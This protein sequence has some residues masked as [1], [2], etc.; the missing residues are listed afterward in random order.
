[1]KKYIVLLSIISFFS[2]CTT[3][4]SQIIKINEWNDGTPRFTHIDSMEN[5]EVDSF[6][7][8][9]TLT[10]TVNQ[11]SGFKFILSGSDWEWPAN[12]SLIS[13]ED[14]DYWNFLG[15]DLY[16]VTDGAGRRV[17]EINPATPEEVWEFKGELGTERYLANPVDAH[18][19][20]E[21]EGQQD[22]DKILITD[23]GRHRVIKVIK[24]NK[25]IQ[26]QYGT[27][28]EGSG[29]NE[30]SDPVDAVPI[31]DS[32]KVFIC[33]KGNKRI[34]LVNEADTSIVWK[35]EA[36]NI[37]TPVDIEYD[38]QN[39]EVLIT[40]QS[41]HTVIKVNVKSNAVTWRFG[42]R[43]VPGAENRLT[44]P[45]DAD[46]LPNG[47]ILICDAG[48]NRLIE[49][50]STK[51]IVWE[52]AKNLENLK[53]ADRL[54]NNKHLIVAGNLP[55]RV[56][57]ISD[58]FTS[59]IQDL[60]LRAS[61]DSLFWD[62]DTVNS[63]TSLK[64][65]L[66][67]EN[68][69]GDIESAEWYG[70][71]ATDSFYTHSGTPINSIHN[72]HR[73]CQ[74]K[75]TLITNNPLYTPQLNDL[76]V[77]YNYYDTRKTG[78]IVTKTIADSIDYIITR[79]KT[80]QYNTIL[81]ENTAL[82]ND[83]EIKLA[84]FD[85]ETNESIASFS[86]S[87]VDTTNEEAL[88]NIE[89]LKK[90]Q[91]IKL[92]ATLQ[93]NNASV[94]PI[95]NN[96]RLEWEKTFSSESHVKFVDENLDSAAYYRLSDSYEPGQPYIDR[97]KVLLDDLNLEQVQDAM[98]LTIKARD[99]KDSILVNLHFQTASGGYVLQP[100]LPAIVFDS[101]VPVFP[102]IL[103]VFDRDL[104][105]V[106]Y[107][108]PTNS[109]D[110]SSDSILVIKDT[111]GTIE[112]ENSA[113]AFIDSVSIGDSVFVHVFD[114][115]DRNFSTTDQD[116]I[117]ITLENSHSRDTEE[118]ILY[119]VAD[120]LGEFNTGEFKSSHGLPLVLD[121]TSSNFDGLL[122][123]IPGSI[124]NIDKNDSY[125]KIPTLFIRSDAPVP[126]TSNYYGGKPLEFQIAPN[127]YYSDAHQTLRVRASSS[128]GT[129]RVLKIEI[130]SLNG[131]KIVEIDESNLSFHY[132]YP[133]PMKQFS[134][135]NNWWDFKNS[136]GNQVSSGTYFVKLTGKVVETNKE[137]S[138]VKKMVIVR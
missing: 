82:R 47:N 45:T 88:Y 27:G 126:D 5:V 1:M 39:D 26:W 86:A 69:L 2:F 85:P 51:Q 4:F 97:I 14:I 118:L 25:D 80:L 68:T 6:V 40:D 49:V 58:E 56:G 12:I 28:V 11:G 136:N 42:E 34:I 21:K 104:L 130:F 102:G 105:I 93:T 41:D 132:Y 48:N 10:G 117:T 65:Q 135:A 74:F 115:N 109:S 19:Y 60:G 70:P 50:D 79:W 91:A 57:Y 71:T 13:A 124:V 43:G 106:S 55:S 64:I 66:R 101:G 7:R 133:I 119:E 15:S 92:V 59:T 63:I 78:R 20:L 33:D 67:S 53:D 81:H 18:Y 107:T 125:G 123:A 35:Y 138:D 16:L 112:F 23:Q 31:P 75:A 120:S 54:V 44:L 22:I 111:E 3:L 129:L 62:S 134:S 24:I 94:T 73:F 46:F 128:I 89:E 38:L 103:E 122:Q 8:L 95:L 121:N 72:G 32:G 17:V 36:P 90:K 52:F 9:T 29:D 76:M 98:N 30:L 87:Q 99:S 77:N 116:L 113:G 61:Y 100:S 114:E 110:T 137:I 127:P 96:L 84:I 37:N 108:D 83:V 131:E